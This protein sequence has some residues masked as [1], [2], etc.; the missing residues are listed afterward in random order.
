MIAGDTEEGDEAPPRSRRKRRRL[1]DP[2]EPP[3]GAFVAILVEAEG[4]L[5]AKVFGGGAEAEAQMAIGVALASWQ[6]VRPDDRCLQGAVV[7]ELVQRPRLPPI[8][9]V[10]YHLHEI[11]MLVEPIRVEEDRQSPPILASLL[12]DHSAREVTSQVVAPAGEWIRHWRG[13][14]GRRRCIVAHLSPGMIREIVHGDLRLFHAVRVTQRTTQSSFLAERPRHQ[15]NKCTHQKK[16]YT[17][18][19]IYISFFFMFLIS[20]CLFIF[21]LHKGDCPVFGFWEWWR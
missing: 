3:T 9:V 6:L 12:S 11:A 1:D 13:E 20:L 10:V 17:E 18:N 19:V 2:G 14:L 4:G 16:K 21:L 8:A 15:V 7:K 5:G